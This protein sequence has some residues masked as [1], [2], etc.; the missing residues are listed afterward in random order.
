M[1]AELISDDST[2]AEK[3]RQRPLKR[4]V[5]K[6][7]APLLSIDEAACFL[8][9]SKG[10]LK[11]LDF[12]GRGI[13]FFLGAVLLNTLVCVE[14]GGAQCGPGTPGSGN[15][16]CG[17][18]ALAN[19]TWGTDDSAFGF[20]ALYSNTGNVYDTEGNSN[21]AIGDTA[22]RDN[23]SGLANTACGGGALI[24]NTAGSYNA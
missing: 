9:T 13:G 22:L 20:D 11:E 18:G 5:A 21:T 10:T 1:V 6:R 2:L 3:E 4:L 8:R 16:A 15:T 17:T 19:N 12:I 14:P 7:K 23:T 24:S